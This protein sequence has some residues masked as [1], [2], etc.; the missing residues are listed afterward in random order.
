MALMYAGFAEKMWALYCNVGHL[1]MENIVHQSGPSP[2]FSSRGGQKPEAGTF[3]K[4]CVGCMQQPVGQTWNGGHRFQMGG[5]GHH[6]PPPLA[7]ALPPIAF[8]F[9]VQMS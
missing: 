1:V 5:G 6:C 3:L 2:G 4:Y 7:T 8:S 9:V